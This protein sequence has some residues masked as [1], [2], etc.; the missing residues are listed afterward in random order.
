MGFTSDSPFRGS[1]G[2]RRDGRGK[3]PRWRHGAESGRRRVG[4]HTPPVKDKEKSETVLRRRVK[5]EGQRDSK[6]SIKPR[7]K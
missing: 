2:P 1:A 3:R 5:A 4:F 6:I 7:S